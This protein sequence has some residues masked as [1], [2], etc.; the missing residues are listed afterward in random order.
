MSV[1]GQLRVWVDVNSA[2]DEGRVGA[3]FEAVQG[4]ALTLTVGDAVTAVDADDNTCQA[5]VTE[6]GDGWLML[7][8]DEST[9]SP[10]LGDTQHDQG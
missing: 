2:D 6:I 5:R 8:M 3:T 10:G 1:E 9:W 4:D 7:A